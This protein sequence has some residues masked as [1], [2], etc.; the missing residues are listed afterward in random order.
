MKKRWPEFL[1]LMMVVSVFVLGVSNGS[2][3]AC[4]NGGCKDAQ[5][6]SREGKFGE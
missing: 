6:E 1:A 5:W 3:S 4:V 2:C